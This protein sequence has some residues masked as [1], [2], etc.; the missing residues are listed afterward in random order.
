MELKA[1]GLNLSNVLK[2]IVFTIKDLINLI[3]WRF[4]LLPKGVPYDKRQNKEYIDWHRS[5]S[6]RIQSYKDLHVGKECYIVG[7]GPSINNIDLG[8]LK[9]KYTIGLNKIVSVNEF[10]A[11]KPNYLVVVDEL[12]IKDLAE[13][14]NTYQMN[15]ITCF[16]KFIEAEGINF[17][18]NVERLWS[19]SGWHHKFDP[20]GVIG[21]GTTVSYVAIQL[22]LFMGFKNIY[23]VGFDHYPEIERDTSTSSNKEFINENHFLQNYS[24]QELNLPDII[25]NE[26]SYKL[27]QHLCGSRGA[28][29]I[30]V[31]PGGY[32]N[33]LP[34]RR[35]SEVIK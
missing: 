7:T 10:Q 19:E 5:F 4:F 13:S 20:T 30:N 31:T 15:G 21:E 11:F 22:A 23:L 34:R 26:A 8:L 24:N 33:L 18:V 32:L 35:L 1:L 6:R 3:F 28:S 29:L 9:T 25:G 17:S 2:R 16:I 27:A 12:I 14:I